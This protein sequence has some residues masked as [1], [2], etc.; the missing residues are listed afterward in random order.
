MSLVRSVFVQASLTA[1]SR[2]LGFLRDTVLFAN[3]GAGPIGD[4]WNTAQQLPNLFRRILAEGAFSQAFSPIYARTRV[5]KGDAEAERIASES[6]SVLFTI[7][8]AV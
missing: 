4:V 8:V 2:F 6:L 7:T 3:I 5:Q 1:L